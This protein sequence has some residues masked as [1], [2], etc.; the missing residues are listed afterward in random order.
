MF[1]RSFWFCIMLVNIHLSYQELVV[2][3]KTR[4]GQY[5]QQHLMADPEK[6]IVVIDFT[7]PDGAKT[8]TL[9]DFSKVIIFV[10]L[11]Y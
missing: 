3:V 6:D 5:T 7:M 8:T 2:N 11:T 4:G 9:I 1:I 10:P